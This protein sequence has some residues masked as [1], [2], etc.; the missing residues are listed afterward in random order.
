MDN[1]Y[2][3][4]SGGIN[5]AS[6]K[7]ELGMN[8]KNIFWA[9]SKNIE[10]L[11]NKG[12]TRQKGNALF[13][14]LPNNDC[15][16]AMQEMKSNDGNKLII[17][18]ESG[19]LYIYDDSSSLIELEKTVSSSK[20]HFLEFLN[21]VIVYGDEDEMFYIKNNETY[22]IVMCNLK[23]EDETPVYP[24]VVTSYKGRIWAAEGSKL[25]FSALGTYDNFE[26]S[27]DAGYINNF[28]TDTHDITALKTYK[29]YLAIY[30]EDSVY[31]LNG[32]NPSDFAITPFAD[33][34]AYSANSIVTVNNK[35]YFFS[36]GI[37]TLQVGDM[38]QV[39]LG[40]EIT[41][42][43]KEEFKN[44]EFKRRREIFALNY[45]EKNQVW[46]FIPYRNDNY[47]HTIWIND[48]VNQ[49]WYKR[50][51]PQ[52]ITCAC[53]FDDYILTGDNKGN[54]Y[55]EDISN[56]FS[57]EAIEFM[58]KSPFLGLGNP[59]V[60]K[61]ID[62]FYFILDESFEN[63]F[64]FSVYKNFDSESQ[65]DPEIIYS[66]NYEN[67][68]WYKENS[69]SEF[70][71]T[72]PDENEN[73]GVWALSTESIYKAEISEANYSVQLCIEGNKPEHN[74]AVIGIQFKEIYNED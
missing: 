32:S 36:S 25:Y 56:T 5:Q 71:D 18:V 7:T 73:E 8:T 2:Y 41:E 21:G 23:H 43:I 11:R 14:S 28:Y 46:Y 39:M 44:F 52:N 53:L 50:V 22:D 12:I 62:E 6:T 74:A 3:N 49:A 26:T 35:Q 9:D 31:L 47:F 29:D 69:T 42:N 45:K 66:N 38:N 57:G 55:R 63:N 20:P 1:F 30:K 33:K 24:S 40:S 10:I 17:S 58:W 13:K 60:R 61:T 59:T 70:H 51:L 4:L 48:I 64:N 65:D 54:I 72:W 15:V 67:L 27:G 37:Y 68:L 19:K 34:G 16:T